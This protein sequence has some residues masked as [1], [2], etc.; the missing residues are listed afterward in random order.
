MPRFVDHMLLDKIFT[1][2]HLTDE[3]FA[4]LSAIIYARFGISISEKK[5]H[6][7]VGRLQELLHKRGFKSF[8]QYL[9][10]L[11]EDQS[12]QA[13]SELANRISTNHTFFFRE[14]EHFD[15]FVSGVLPEL[16]ARLKAQNSR[17]LRI[18]CAGCA[19]G[20]EAYTLAMLMLEFFGLDYGSWSAGVLATDISTRALAFARAGVYPEERAASVPPALKAR[21]LKR[22]GADEVVICERLAR[23]VTFR[24]FNLM[25]PLFPF[26][27]PFH[28]IFCR[29]V[30]M[31][32]DASTR[33]SL[34]RRLY[35]ATEPGGY[36]FIGHSESLDL[37]CC[38]Y[39]YLMPAVY[40][41]GRV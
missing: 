3:E 11:S 33:A 9:A 10:C 37:G 41:K 18:W 24:R 35:A 30:M 5:R 25:N 16:A 20:E 1:T 23:E 40:R 29:N 28:V 8:N 7:L 38:P 36:L 39:H 17:D 27:K 14:R 22:K 21:Y 6:L 15:F 4:E 31:Y 34:V 26:R 13:M 32:F 12:G 2:P 19:S